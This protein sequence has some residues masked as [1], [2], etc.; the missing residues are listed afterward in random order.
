MT[1]QIPTTSPN[2]G[3]EQQPNPQTRRSVAPTRQPTQ[4]DLRFNDR[5][6]EAALRWPEHSGIALPTSVENPEQ[7]HV[8]S[9]RG[10]LRSPLADLN[11]PPE[12]RWLVPA[13]RRR[14]V[15]PRG[16]RPPGRD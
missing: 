8:A 11:A 6:G 16:P 13:I 15:I 2:R 10:V 14:P 9:S 5:F 4:R 1:E 12:H 7:S 3:K